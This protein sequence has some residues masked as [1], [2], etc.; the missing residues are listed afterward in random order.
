MKDVRGQAD[1]YA[2][3]VR[4]LINGLMRDFVAVLLVIGASVL[5]KID[6]STLYLPTAN[7]LLNFRWLLDS[8]NYLY[9]GVS[10]MLK[11]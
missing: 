1:L 8:Q 2:S 4:E 6:L 11:A 10:R 9:F 3:K 5:A 7:M